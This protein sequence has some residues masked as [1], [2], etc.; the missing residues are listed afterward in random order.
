MAMTK[1]EKGLITWIDLKTRSIQFTK[2]ISELLGHGTSDI[3]SNGS[4][5][6]GSIY[7]FGGFTALST[8][9]RLYH[10]R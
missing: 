10:D 5:K 9:Y 2:C 7:L 1:M 6:K 8:L 3:N 4:L